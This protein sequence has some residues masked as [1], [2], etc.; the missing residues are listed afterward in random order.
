MN[1]IKKTVIATAL[2]AATS[3]AA[4]A[5]ISGNVS[6]AT[7]YRFRGI[8]QTD[9]DPAIQGGFDWAHDSGLY[10]GVWAS[11]LQFAG[12]IEMDYYGG[13]SGEMGNG[14]GYDVG[15]IYYDYPSDNQGTGPDLEFVEFYGGLS[16]SV[17]GADLSA[18]ISYS[19][20]YFGETDT[21]IYY[22]AGADFSLPADFGAS[23]H[24]GYQT[25]DEGKASQGGFFSS[26]EDS[27][28]DW[29]VGICNAA[30]G[31]DLGLTYVDT[32]LDDA[33]CFSSSICD[34]TVIFSVSKSL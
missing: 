21:G 17:G 32:N 5:E 3:T 16:G 34:S 4:L 27:Y 15:I 18:K 30:G 24:V 10:A 20:D 14:L 2:L 6:L 33:D 29:S 8:S 22:E 31:V 7:D 23:L 25:I 26:E 9:N 12:S 11:N 19:P 13:F 28:V 1:M